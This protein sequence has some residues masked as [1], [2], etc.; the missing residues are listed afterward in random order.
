MNSK[1]KNF[2]ENMVNADD[3][4]IFMLHELMERWDYYLLQIA[5]SRHLTSTFLSH[6]IEGESTVHL[7]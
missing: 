5:N 6:M 1:K 7:R 3:Y 4:E 2:G